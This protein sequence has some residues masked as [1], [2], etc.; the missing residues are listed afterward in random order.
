M[1]GL[2]LGIKEN[3]YQTLVHIYDHLGDTMKDLHWL[4][5]SYRIQYKIL[6][7]VYKC[8]NGMGPDYLSN[9]FH[10]ANYN[11]FIYLT[12]PRVYMHYGERSF[13][14]VGPKLWNELPLE[15]KN[16]MSLDSFKVYLKTFLFK[17]AYDIN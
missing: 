12:E 10:Y 15:I 7:L 13:Q 2:K 6:L 4:P 16:C 1:T 17:R 3:C 5:I 8:L 14:K 9:M 11:H